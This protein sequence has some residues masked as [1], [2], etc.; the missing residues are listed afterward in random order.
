MQDLKRFQTIPAVLMLLSNIVRA[1]SQWVLVWIFALLGGPGVVGEYTLA[2]AIATPIFIAFE[3]SLRNVIVTLR[4]PI[5]FVRFWLVRG[6]AAALALVVL[7]AVAGISRSQ[8]YVLL[9]VG[10]IKVADSVLDLSYGALQK[11]GE[12][13]RIALTS[14]LNSV[15]TVAIGVVAYWVTHSIELSLVGSL[16]GS[17][18][19]AT[20]VFAPVLRSERAGGLVAGPRWN[21]VGAI[22]RAGIPSGLAFASISLLTYMPIYFLGATAD[23]DQVGL[24]AVLAYFPT[25][26]NL[27]YGSVQQS[28][29]HSYVYHYSN[30]GNR[31]LLKYALLQGWPLLICGIVSGI[32]TFLLGRDLVMILY[33]K[34]FSLAFGEILP[35]AIAMTLLPVIFVSGA[36]LLTKN[37]YTF[38]FVIGVIS[39]LLT[40]AVGLVL[41]P[42]DVA[43]AG[44]VLLVGTGSR[45][46][47]GAASAWYALSQE[48]IN[49]VT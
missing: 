1:G 25:F 23:L 47:L 33:G 13:L 26:A 41:A 37:L 21:E 24:F 38:Q 27:L 7:V 28:T 3:M 17:V 22:I 18:L 2:I 9:L 49:Q 15:V 4:R 20:L 40:V 10:L 5:A 36:V 46:M 43:D 34:G 32:V 11:R 29:L 42:I 14:L 35:I 45:A 30:A 19:T 39:L 44:M 6:V 48:S 16:I 31:A 12:I 8:F